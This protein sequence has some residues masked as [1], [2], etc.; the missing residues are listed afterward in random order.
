MN[1]IESLYERFSGSVEIHQTCSIDPDVKI[2]ID[3]GGRLVME[4]NVSIMRG[5]SI[6]I[7]KN[8]VVKLRKN[9]KIGKN[10]FIG[11]MCYLDVGEGSGISNMVDIHDHNHNNIRVF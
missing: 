3:H 2:D 6:F 10:V 7:M 5:T 11:V 9:V 1:Y 4:E 8:A